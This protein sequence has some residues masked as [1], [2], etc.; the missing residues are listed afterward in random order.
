ME[1]TQI[2]KKISDQS[3]AVFLHN[4][5]ERLKALISACNTK[6]DN[7][8]DSGLSSQGMGG[9]KIVEILEDELGTV[10]QVLERLAE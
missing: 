6:V 3:A 7:L 4:Y 10:H 9:S 5:E 2:T 1:L 8:N